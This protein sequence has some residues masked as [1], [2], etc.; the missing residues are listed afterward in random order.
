MVRSYFYGEPL[1]AG[2]T[3]NGNGSGSSFNLDGLMGKTVP[4]GL[5][6]SPYS[7]QIGWETLSV[8]RVGEGRSQWP[9]KWNV[10]LARSQA[11]RKRFPWISPG[12]LS[13]WRGLTGRRFSP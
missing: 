5:G 13:S 8:L 12:A 10:G 1:A 2:S 4:R 7:F 3:A 11:A 6:L 9:Q